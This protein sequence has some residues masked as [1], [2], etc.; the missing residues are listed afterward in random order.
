MEPDFTYKQYEE[1][2]KETK[3]HYK[4]ILFKEEKKQG[5]ILLRHDVDFDIKG[6]LKFGEIENS[7]GIKSTHFIFLR[8]PFYNVLTG[9]NSK[10]IFKLIEQGH[11]IGLHFDNAINDKAIID[12]V[13]IEAEVLEKA[14][15]II[16]HSVSFHRPGILADAHVDLGRFTNAYAL[17]DYKYISDS[18]MNF[19]EGPPLDMIK[20]KQF[21]KLHVLLHP[22]W[23]KE[24]PGTRDGRIED[25]LNQALET[26]KI[27]T[28]ENTDFYKKV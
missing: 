9:R 17:K 16:V 2:L 21:D 18:R 11:E 22:V 13:Q 19:R 27:E 23:W 8:S 3:E 14:F 4:F 20:S 5:T 1:L 10:I 28:G 6:T 25:F 7:L 24:N 15:G 26:L 12:A